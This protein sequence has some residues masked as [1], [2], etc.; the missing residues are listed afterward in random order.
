V[1]AKE[2][3]R[4]TSQ[5]IAALAGVSRSTVSRV[6]NGYGNVPE[7]T[8]RKVMRVVEQYGYVP[9][10]SA[11]VL[12]GGNNSVIG[13]F[14]VDC[15]SGTA[16]RKMS[17]SGYFSPFLA[18]TID[19]A[20]GLGLHVLACM[21]AS[22]AD[23]ADVQ[24]IFLEQTVAGGI[25]IGEQNSSELKKI[26]RLGCKVVVVDGGMECG[27]AVAVNADNFSGA[28]QMTKYLIELG[29]R[30][31]AHI[32]GPQSQLS[33]Q[34]RLCGYR[35]A[36]EEAGLPFVPELVEC[37]DFMRE[38]G[39]K[40]T[41]ALLERTAQSAPTAAFFG[42]D[43]MALGG[44]EVIREKGLS[45]PEDISIAGFDNVELAQYSQPALTTVCLPFQEM[46]SLAVHGLE[47][48]INGRIAEGCTAQYRVPVEI[49]KRD[50]CAAPRV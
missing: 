35:K 14:M 21:V 44:M 13:L 10:A 42:N 17:L 31:I 47:D 43:S 27:G 48:L 25:F 24:R 6:I 32:A 1:Y 50:S 39:R 23:Y 5:E 30:R 34:E 46:S 19:S 15:K 2:G 8:R 38:G 18:G 11:R 41:R 22:S 45:I 4:I 26:I 16:G 33:A 3:K 40:A 12:A 29:H 49:V 7:Q 37:G 28:Y 36:L 20:S 9:H